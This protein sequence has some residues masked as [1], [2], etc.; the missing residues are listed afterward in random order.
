MVSN[1]DGNLRATHDRDVRELEE[2]WEADRRRHRIFGVGGVVLALA[3]IGSIW[4]AYPLL[5]RHDQALTQFA[6]VPKVVDALGDRVKD[7]DTKVENW[8]SD[9]RD[10][11]DQV[12]KLGHQMG[13]QIQAVR[14]RAQETSTEL[15]RRVQAQIDGQIQSMQ[16]RLARVESASEGD[17]MRLATLQRE[18]GQMRGE[19]AKQ[20]EE[21]SAV[22][23]DMDQRGSDHENQLASLS[24]REQRDRRDVDTIA[25]KIA[26]ER[27]GF[28]VTKNHSRELVP[29]I[30]L[31]ITS[32]DVLYRRASG[33]IWVM[34]DRRTIWLR[35][36][37]AQEPVIFY[38][39]R[40][41]R[42]RELVIT[43][44]AKGS[45]TGYLLLPKEADAPVGAA[46]PQTGGE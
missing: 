37:G 46:N 6:G 4:Y 3:I 9:Q 39:V 8:T 31:G 29:G 5:T 45:V 34:P 24:D 10:L 12:A 27:V 15:L 17:Q 11:R 30:S 32:T 16:T 42:K 41:G 43:N 19:M 13:A 33:W 20:A 44:V 18:V 25:Q 2:R 22:R 40:D 23:R 36:K 38:G 1:N 21:L 35:G 26:V 7:V 28:E 14:K